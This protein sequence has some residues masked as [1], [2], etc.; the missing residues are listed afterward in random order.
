VVVGLSLGAAAT[1]RL[2]QRRSDGKFERQA[3]PLTPRGAYVLDGEVRHD[4]EHSIAA[5]EETRW[6]ITF[7]SLSDLGKRA[8]G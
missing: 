4:W 6:S 3:V 7:R 2:R 1:L 5:V 8:L